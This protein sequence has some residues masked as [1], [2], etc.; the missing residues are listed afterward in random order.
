MVE[1][2]RVDLIAEHQT[3]EVF[4]KQRIIGGV[5]FTEIFLAE[6]A[7]A[8]SFALLLK[9]FGGDA[10]AFGGGDGEPFPEIAAFGPAR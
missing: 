10:R 6:V 5:E 1:H 7:C 3:D 2:E 9:E 4:V 8:A